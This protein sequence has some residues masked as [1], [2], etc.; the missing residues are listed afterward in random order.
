MTVKT[1][2]TAVQPLKVMPRPKTK[3][4]VANP[5]PIFFILLSLYVT[6]EFWIQ[7]GTTFIYAMFHNGEM[8]SWKWLGMYAIILTILLVTFIWIIGFPILKL[9]QDLI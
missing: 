3:V 1:H 8:P 6:I 9:E 7:T 4:E 5:W 2:K